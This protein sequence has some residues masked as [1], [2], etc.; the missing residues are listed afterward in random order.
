MPAVVLLLVTII[1][2]QTLCATRVDDR[3]SLSCDSPSDH[4][5]PTA[6]IT[7][8]A[9]LQPKL[10]IGLMPSRYL[11]LIQTMHGYALSC[12]P[13]VAFDG[14]NFLPAGYS[15]DLGIYYL[16]PWVSRTF[17]LTL[18]KSIV[19]VLFSTML[20]GLAVGCWGFLFALQSRA[21]KQI[22][23]IALLFLTAIAYHVGDVYVFEFAV[24][25]AVL[26]WALYFF[27]VKTSTSVVFLCF[28]AGVGMV[29]GTGS[30][31]R[32]SSAPPTLAVIA[33]LLVVYVHASIR[34][35]GAL[36]AVLLLSFFLPRLYFQHLTSERDA[37]LMPRVAGYQAGESRHALGHFAYAGL[38]FLSN[39]YVPGGVSD[40]V[41]KDKVQA[42]A[43]GVAYLSLEYDK[44]LRH[45]V[46]SIAIHHPNLFLFTIF[47][48]LGVVAGVILVFANIGLFA[49]LM[50]PKP[51]QLDLAFW[52]AFAI[53]AAPMVLFAP[54][55]LYLLGVISLA[56]VYGVVSL[57][58]A[59]ASRTK[60]QGAG[61]VLRHE[62]DPS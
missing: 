18:V 15:D 2:C 27:R 28:I 5:L 58:Q 8:L 48:K 9:R 62:C 20:L 43:P 60:K 7:S 33:L 10:S 53:S 29:T 32:F 31:V 59:F 30:L 38:G 26:P 1:G 4:V 12:T 24:C 16:V 47:A 13:L 14:N 41:S 44:V 42:V 21:G 19:S 25:L 3:Q 57:D 46:M 55:P 51:W 37:F 17:H 50:Y 61:Q 23:I 22:S 40:E 11:D 36:V 39:P 45:E 54:V 56:T 52:I 6:E 35:K 49:A 34:R